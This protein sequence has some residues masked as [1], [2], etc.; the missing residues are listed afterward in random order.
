MAFVAFVAYPN[1]I[2]NYCIYRY[3]CYETLYCRIKTFENVGNCYIGAISATM[4][5][6]S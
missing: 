1:A 5:Q 2:L 6:I 4:R 3:L